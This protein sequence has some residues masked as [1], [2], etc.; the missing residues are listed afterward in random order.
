MAP[1][2]KESEGISLLSI[3]G[4]EDDDIEEDV[5]RDNGSNTNDDSET[6]NNTN[7]IKGAVVNLDSG[8]DNTTPDSIGNLT[9]PSPAVQQ[10]IIDKLQEKFIKFLLI[11]KKTGR[12]FNS[13]LRNRKDFR[14]PDFLTHA[15]TYH[16]IDEIGSCLSKDVF[17]VHG[18]DKSDFYDEI[19]ADFDLKREAKRKDEEKK[20]IQKIDFL[21]RGGGSNP[22]SVAVDMATCE[23]RLNKKSKWD[24]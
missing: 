18:C 11:K 22:V 6:L 13:E 20:K 14:N 15:V 10:A 1:E 17:N 23:G 8:N 24:N 21:F 12:S 9:H 4:D 5:E 16:N 7:I 19:D 2:K 3:Y